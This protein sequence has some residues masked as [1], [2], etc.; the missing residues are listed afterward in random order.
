[1]RNLYRFIGVFISSVG[2]AVHRRTGDLLIKT[3]L[4]VISALFVTAC[5]PVDVHTWWAIHGDGSELE[6]AAVHLIVDGATEDCLPDHDGPRDVECVIRDAW[7][8]HDLHESI[9][10]WS[11]GQLIWCE[12]RFNPDAR[13]SSS[14][15]GGLGQHIPAYWPGRAAAAGHEGASIYDARSNAYVT[16]WLYLNQG[17]RPWSASSH[18]HGLF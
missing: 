9:G 6:S 15:A 3:A 2:D 8:H 1:M 12:S 11:F 14:G 16:A 5:R 13:N 10:L 18:C 4:I 7:Q 17:A